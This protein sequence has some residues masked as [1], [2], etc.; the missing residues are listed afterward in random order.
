MVDMVD[1]VDTADMVEPLDM[2]EANVQKNFT[3][4]PSAPVQGKY[5]FT[6][7]T[8]DQIP[9]ARP[10]RMS[11][12]FPHIEMNSTNPLDPRCPALSKSLASPMTKV[13]TAHHP[14]NP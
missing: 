10:S 1:M 9:R 11:R 2:V 8:A 5:L 6:P 3:L 7:R 14:S 4:L 13:Q 12:H